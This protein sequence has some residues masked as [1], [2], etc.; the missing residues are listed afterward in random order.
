[1]PM[2]DPEKIPPELWK[3]MNVTKE[4]FIAIQARMEER[5][6]KA[7]PVGASAP[8]FVLERLSADGKRTGTTLRL[9]S[10]RGRPVA[11]VFGSYT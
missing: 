6:R 9:S 10:L 1:M 4:G 2:P 3:Q 7:P 8:D 11:L 5:D